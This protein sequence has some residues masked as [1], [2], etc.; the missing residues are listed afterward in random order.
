MTLKASVYPQMIN[1]S[2]YWTFTTEN[3]IFVDTLYSLQPTW[4]FKDATMEAIASSLQLNQNSSMSLP[5]AY[6]R[7]EAF[8]GV[9]VNYTN[10]DNTFLIYE[11]LNFVPQSCQ[12]YIV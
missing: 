2:L 4:Q 5:V 8:Y 11:D 10:T 12:Y 9:R 6:F 3:S 7:D 1:S